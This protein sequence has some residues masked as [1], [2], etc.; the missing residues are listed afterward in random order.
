MSAR[1]ETILSLGRQ[2]AGGAEMRATPPLDGETHENASFIEDRNC[3]PAQSLQAS[4][5][6]PR[7]KSAL[8]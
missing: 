5:S 4:V 3:G 1:L 8:L 7:G 6:R 2:K